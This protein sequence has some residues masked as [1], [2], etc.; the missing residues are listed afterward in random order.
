M[1]ELDIFRVLTQVRA[2]GPE[3]VFHEPINPRGANFQ[4]CLEAARERGY[5]DVVEEFERI[6]DHDEWVKYAVDQLETVRREAAKIDGL[7]VHSWPSKGLLDAV[8]SGYKKRLREMRQT[9]SP[10]AF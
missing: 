9:V 5:Q 3:V 6:Q 4:M 7:Q 1:D 8:G 10:E 2:V